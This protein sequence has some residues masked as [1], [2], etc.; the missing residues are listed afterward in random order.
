MLPNRRWAARHEGIPSAS[1]LSFHSREA[2]LSLT[3]HRGDRGPLSVLFLG[4]HSDDIEIGC[5]GTVSRL[6]AAYPDVS[7]HWIVFGT[8]GERAKEAFRSARRLLRRAK[9]PQVSVEGFRDGFF[10]YQGA[11]LKTYF[12]RL[13][14]AVS[15]DAIFTHHQADRHQDHRVIAELT[16]NTFRDHFILEYEIPKYDGG[17]VT[18]NHFVQLD[19]ATCR[20]KVGHLMKAFPSQAGKRWWGEDTFLGLMRLRGV[21]S[22]SRTG[23]AEGFHVPKAMF[24]W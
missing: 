12:E 3:P 22:G 17:L 5:G 14:T 23:Y 16:W 21:E 18:P 13:K 20:R 24:Q 10:P 11:D 6:L 1:R 19:V 7:I 2:V 8:S 9:D 15:P 4:A